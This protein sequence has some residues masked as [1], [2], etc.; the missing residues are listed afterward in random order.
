M[1][2][3]SLLQI[4]KWMGYVALGFSALIAVGLWFLIFTI[5]HWTS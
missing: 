3:R 1:D 5:L 2:V 4:F